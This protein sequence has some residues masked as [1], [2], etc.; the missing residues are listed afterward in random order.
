MADPVQVK[1]IY[2]APEPADGA[3]FLVDRLWPRGVSKEKAALAAWLKALAPSDALRR[4]FH[5]AGDQSDEAW[6]AFRSAYF[7]E[8]GAGGAELSAALEELAQ[9]RRQ[10]PVTLLFTEHNEAR[11][12]AT[13]LAQWLSR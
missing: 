10:G 1:R 2:A 3:R 13:A 6:Q 7:A 9:A 5:G 8:L 4:E 12:N 11:N